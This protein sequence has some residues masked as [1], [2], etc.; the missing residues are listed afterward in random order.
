[1]LGAGVFVLGT[2]SLLLPRKTRVYARQPH[3]R[4]AAAGLASGVERR[5]SAQ[6][7][8]HIAS[9]I[10][11]LDIFSEVIRPVT[12]P[13]SKL[14]HRLREAW[15]FILQIRLRAIWPLVLVTRGLPFKL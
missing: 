13:V 9:R 15:G 10:S 11:L 6:L 14:L 2:E 7:S 3:I 1:M 4:L 8:R 12:A 5:M